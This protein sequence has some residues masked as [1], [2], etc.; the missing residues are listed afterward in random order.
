MGN[1]DTISRAQTRE[2]VYAALFAAIIAALSQ[3]SVPIPTGV[4]ITLQTFAVALAGYMLGK[5]WGTVSAAVY[6][7]LG[8]VGAPVFAGFKGGFASLSG[9]TGGFIW[10]FIGMALLCGLGGEMKNRYVSVLLGL[11]GLCVCHLCGVA[12]WTAI[13]GGG[14]LSGFLTVSA[15]YLLKDGISV[16][17]A[18]LAAE[19]VKRRITF[20]TS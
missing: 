17:C 8:A 20:R 15:P 12:Q 11:G 14:L 5:K 3:V 16:I 2:M 13:K 1:R 7:L 10:G 6:V 18:Y 9:V 4:P 19:T